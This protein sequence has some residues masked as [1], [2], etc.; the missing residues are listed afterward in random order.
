MSVWLG[1]VFF[2]NLPPNVIT[3]FRISLY[4]LASARVLWMVIQ[5]SVI[6]FH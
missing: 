5:N 4:P 3:K 1:F 6:S 2:T